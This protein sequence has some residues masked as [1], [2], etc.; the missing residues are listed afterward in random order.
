MHECENDRKRRKMASEMVDAARDPLPALAVLQLVR[1]L[2]DPLDFTVQLDRGLDL[3]LVLLVNEA[4]GD[5]RKKKR[6]MDRNAHHAP[7]TRI[8]FF[9]LT[10][11]RSMSDSPSWIEETVAT[12]LSRLC[13]RE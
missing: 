13:V 7:K 12:S 3:H 2:T 11:E 10:I 8:F 6:S 1:S 4:L 5:L 9:K